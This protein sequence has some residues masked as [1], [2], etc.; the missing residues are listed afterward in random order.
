MDLTIPKVLD[1]FRVG[2]LLDI[3]ER[4]MKEPARHVMQLGYPGRAHGLRS[5]PWG[6]WEHTFDEMCDEAEWAKADGVNAA[7]DS[8]DTQHQMSIYHKHLYAVYKFSRLDLEAIYQQARDILGVELPK[9]LI[10]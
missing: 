8:M 2:E 9:R 7:I 3:W 1:D 5:E 6:Y 4:S 10:Y